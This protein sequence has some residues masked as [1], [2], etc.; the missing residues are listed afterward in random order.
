MCCFF[1]REP[2]H[3][4]DFFVYFVERDLLPGRIIYPLFVTTCLLRA[5]ANLRKINIGREPFVGSLVQQCEQVGRKPKRPLEQRV[6]NIKAH[7]FGFRGTNL[8]F[9]AFKQR[10]GIGKLGCRFVEKRFVREKITLD[11]K[12]SSDRGFKPLQSP[13]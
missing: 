13:A 8:L 2:R 6:K 3:V 9:Y 11:F 4:P 10:K 5:A 1:G 12:S 7:R